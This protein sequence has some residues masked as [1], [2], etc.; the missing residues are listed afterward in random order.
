MLET[1]DQPLIQEILI[2]VVFY[3]CT[4]K[5]FEQQKGCSERG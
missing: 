1:L 3:N 4:I 2:I 5:Q